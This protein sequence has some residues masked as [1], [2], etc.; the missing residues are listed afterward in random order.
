MKTLSA[1][2]LEGGGGRAGL[3]DTPPPKWKPARL[4]LLVGEG[5]L[6]IRFYIGDEEV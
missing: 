4:W 3:R 6:L 2:G 5:L 1:L